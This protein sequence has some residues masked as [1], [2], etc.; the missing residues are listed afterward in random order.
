MRSSA[1]GV[2][3]DRTG[4]SNGSRS[5]DKGVDFANYLCTY[6]LLYHQKEMLYDRVRMEAYYN[7]IFENKHHFHGKTVLDE[8][9]G[10]EFLQSGQGKLVL[11]KSMQWKQ[12]RC[13]N[14]YS[15]A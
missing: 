8:E 6:A 12:Q 2:A 4:T 15:Q 5:V 10:V 3:G 13:R 9:L 7:V 1:N 11:E 14:M